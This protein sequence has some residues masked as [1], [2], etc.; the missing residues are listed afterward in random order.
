MPGPQSRISGSLAPWRRVRAAA[1]TTMSTRETA[2]AAPGP[3]RT[4]PCPSC[5]F[6]SHPSPHCSMHLRCCDST[7]MRSRCCFEALTCVSPPPW[8][9]PTPLS[10]PCAPPAPPQLLP[11]ASPALDRSRVSA[12][13]IA[14]RLRSRA[15]LVLLKA[16]KARGRGRSGSA[17]GAERGACARAHAGGDRRCEQGARMRGARRGSGPR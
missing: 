5:H 14:D 17:K 13:V 10:H 6:A 8:S 15:T 3:P 16:G 4:R 9:P 11:P 7:V 2:A 12:V 1:K